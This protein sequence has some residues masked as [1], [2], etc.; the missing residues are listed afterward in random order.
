MKTTGRYCGASSEYDL[1][2]VINKEVDDM[3]RVVIAG[4]D[5]DGNPEN[6]KAI[7]KAMIETL[8]GEL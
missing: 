8:L 5:D 3:K 1:D 7:V 6:R 2:H 4:I